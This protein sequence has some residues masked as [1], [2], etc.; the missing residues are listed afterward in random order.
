MKKFIS[1]IICMAVLLSVVGC[2][3]NKY[4]PV[5]STEEEARVVMTVKI[6]DKEYDVRYELYRALFL[7]N[8]ADVD[9]ADSSVWSGESA[10]E[11][12]ERINAIIADSLCEI[13]SVFYVAE[14]IGFDPYSDKADYEVEQYIIGAV[15]GDENQLGHGT[16]DKYLES[17]KKQNLNYSTAD[18]LLRYALAEEAV[19]EHYRGSVNEVG[20]REGEYEFTKNDVKEY[21]ESDASVRFL[22]M[23]IQHGTSTL[24]EAE[25]HRRNLLGYTDEM[26]RATYII[27]NTM[28]TESDLIS[29]GKI[30][31]IVMGKNELTSPVYSEF[32]EQIFGLSDGEMSEVIKLT[33]SDADGYYI[34]YRVAK[35]EEHFERCYSVIESSYLDDVIGKEIKSAQNEAKSNIRMTEKYFEIT[36]SEISMQ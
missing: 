10:P 8:K 2:A 21:Y 35:S 26:N 23:Y 3:E 36:H 29:G 11:Y 20:I 17:L 32:T 27:R 22:Q 19:A 24:L 14:K 7:N 25:E 6:A 33:G 31:G 30:T 13:F 28:A 5:E 16:Y 1:I 18:L 9:G 34:I 15:E 4:P 12:V